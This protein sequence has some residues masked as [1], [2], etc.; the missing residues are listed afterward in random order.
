MADMLQGEVALA[1]RTRAASHATALPL[2]LVDRLYL[3]YFFGLGVLI[4]ALR[5]HLPAWP[6][7]LA[8]HGLCLA[9][10]LLATGARRDRVCN[11]LH[12]WY[13]LVAFIVCFE[14]VARL[15][16]LVVDGWQDAWLLA[17]EG[18]WRNV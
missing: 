14:E 7:Y 15:S 13:P 16:F 6:A 9:L 18:K 12:D 10:L 8:L 1:A 17:L 5:Q 4:F 11:F 2:N 3:G